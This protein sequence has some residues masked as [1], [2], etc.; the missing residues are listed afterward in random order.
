MK[1]D[2]QRFFQLSAEVKSIYKKCI[3]LEATGGTLN[4]QSKGGSPFT[5]FDRSSVDRD[6]ELPQRELKNHSFQ[7]FLY[8]IAY[9][10]ETEYKLPFE[11]NVTFTGNVDIRL[12]G[13]TVE[14]LNMNKLNEELKKYGLVLVEKEWPVQ[15]LVLTD[16][17]KPVQ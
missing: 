2:L 4:I 15:C 8:S 5:T 16:K 1:Q 7:L 10:L 12:S 11:S 6:I 9:W 14:S 13:E 17:L 3:V